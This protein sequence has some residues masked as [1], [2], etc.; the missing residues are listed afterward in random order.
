MG[1]QAITH[2]CG[3]ESRQQMYGR[4]DARERR[5]ASLGQYPCPECRARQGE[6]RGCKPL[7]GSDKQRAWAGDIRARYL[8]AHPELTPEE[9]AQLS[10]QSS[11]WIDRRTS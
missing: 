4:Y 7:L 9:C 11:W 10:Q 6:E 2:S 3:H 8:A 1:W 5:A